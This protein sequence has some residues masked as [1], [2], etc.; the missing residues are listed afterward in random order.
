[1]DDK[2]RWGLTE[3]DIRGI[4]RVIL[5]NER[6]MHVLFADN[7][8]KGMITRF[9]AFLVRQ[10]EQELQRE[11]AVDD[12]KTALAA[13]NRRQDRKL[14][15]IGLVISSLLLWPIIWPAI[16]NIIHAAISETPSVTYS[17]P[18]PQSAGL[19]AQYDQTRR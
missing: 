15:I 19:P 5:E 17:Q 8:E 3:E 7:G 10:D 13:H 18:K 2:C 6:I 1:M 14:V 12:V 16:R 11:G 9:N 4:R